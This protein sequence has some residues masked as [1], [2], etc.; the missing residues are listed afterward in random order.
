M[1]LKY[2]KRRSV[3]K[4]FFSF[5]G[6]SRLWTIACVRFQIKFI[7][8]FKVDRQSEC[9]LHSIP[10]II[11]RI[12]D[13]GYKKEKPTW[14]NNENCLRNAVCHFPVA[15]CEWHVIADN[16]S[17]KTL[18]MIRTYLPEDS[19]HTVHFGHGA[20]SFRYGYELALKY[21]DNRIIYFLENDYLHRAKAAIVLREGLELGVADYVT[22]YD[23]PDKYGYDGN[24]FVRGGEKTKVF[25]SKT[26]HWK[27]TNSTPL[28]F[29]TT[30][31]VLKR[32]KN[33]M[34]KWT[35]TTLPKSF[36][37]FTDL[38]GKGRRLISPIPGFSTHGEV[39]FLT[40][41]VDWQQEI[42]K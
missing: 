6:I 14:I 34:Y 18:N 33:I 11:Y 42:I 12:S 36:Y 2:E 32:D 26:C 5:M 10:V 29:A 23:H 9:K 24:P 35:D 40:P 3:W 15:T 7:K 4:E 17:A 41:L 27:I 16:L 22:L 31:R 28:T 30:V 25:I 39:A 21:A 19:I 37:I 20:G 13:V 38:A 1:E 8:L